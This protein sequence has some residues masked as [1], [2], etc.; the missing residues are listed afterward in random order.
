MSAIYYF[1][2]KDHNQRLV[3]GRVRASSRAEVEEKLIAR[4]LVLIQAD[5]KKTVTIISHWWCFK[6][7]FGY[8]LSTAFFF[9]QC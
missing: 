2:A 5:T 8:C 4:Q 3:K 9:D 6:K 1:Q 7:R